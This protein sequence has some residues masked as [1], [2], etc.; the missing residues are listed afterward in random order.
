MTVGTDLPAPGTADAAR[1]TPDA[2]TP[3]VVRGDGT[4]ARSRAARRWR[5]ARWA[6]LVIGVLLLVV[7]V[8]AVTRPVT[9]STPYSPDNPG[10]GGARAVAQVLGDQGVDVQHVTHVADAVSAAGPGTT[11][12]VTPSLL[13]PEQAHA[14]AGVEADLVLLGAD[15]TLVG[16]ATDGDVGRVQ[17]PATSGYPFAPGCDLP[18]AQRAG[19]LQLVSGL[20]ADPTATRDV[21]LCWVVDD[22]AALAQVE[23]PTPGG[24]RTVTAVDDPSFVRNDTVLEDGNAA[25]ALGLLGAHEKLVWLV[26]DP[27]DT[28]ASGDTSPSAGSVLPPWAGVVGLWALLVVVVAGVWRARRLGPLVAEELP[29]VVRATE[30]TRGR[31]RLYRRA[32]SRGHA[33]AGLRAST[34]DVVARRLGVPRSAD[35]TSLTDAVSRATGRSA[36]D[37]AD[38]LYGPPPPDDD[39]LAELARRLDTL[40]SEVHRS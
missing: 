15:D 5:R 10:P 33:A 38:L 4:T 12:L 34:A 8:L 26:P 13:L 37:V 20:A 18:V 17:A 6:V 28:S 7:A 16:A 30:T 27:L 23:R 2:T 14:L 19:A 35:P 29:V 1:E 25:L 21:T 32:R 31:G 39:A 24:T 40:E 3:A 36:H 22:R 11:L 9:S